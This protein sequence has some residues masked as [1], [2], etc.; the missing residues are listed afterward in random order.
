M[1]DDNVT[2]AAAASFADPGTQLRAAR[3]KMGVD[4]LDLAEILKVSP[5]RLEALEAGR[6]HE[7][8]DLV[9][10]RALAASICR[11]L[12][13]DPADILARLPHVVTPRISQDDS[14]PHSTLRD[15]SPSPWRVLWMYASHPMGVGILLACVGIGIVLWMPPQS[16]PQHDMPM[17]T[18][19]MPVPTPWHDASAPSMEAFPPSAEGESALPLSA[20]LSPSAAGSAS[21]PPASTSSATLHPALHPSIHSSF[22]PSVNTSP[23]TAPSGTLTLALRAIDS[24]WV[25]IVDAQ[26]TQV[27]RRMLLAGEITQ[28]SGIPP[29]SVLLGKADGVEV[30]VRGNKFDTLAHAQRN[31]AR[32]EVR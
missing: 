4:I 27:L 1:N 8:P 5:E 13:I 16:A 26:G 6:L 30:T 9:F 25:E 22:G 10:A 7:L 20:P 11:V 24:S 14:G 19:V 15:P 32:F 12:Q 23:D 31:V 29:L 2:W 18:V 21:P 17:P 28:A 3:E